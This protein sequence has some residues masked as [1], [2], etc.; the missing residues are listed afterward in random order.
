MTYALKDILLLNHQ[1]FALKE[2]EN[3]KIFECGTTCATKKATIGCS[4]GE[5]ALIET[6]E[7]R[8]GEPTEGS[9]IGKTITS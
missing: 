6:F 4:L 3:Y 5:Q 8:F 9:L 1:A 7:S 2:G